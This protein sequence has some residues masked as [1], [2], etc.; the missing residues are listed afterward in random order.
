MSTTVPP[1]PPVGD[2]FAMAWSLAGLSPDGAGSSTLQR[3]STSP[4]SQ[5]PRLPQVGVGDAQDDMFSVEQRLGA[6]GMGV[7]D[8]ARDLVLDRTVAL[9]RP[10]LGAG[11]RVNG[12]LVSEAR[13]LAA[14][15][16][17]NIVPVHALGQDVDGAAILVMKRVIGLP[18][19]EIASRSPDLERDVRIALDGPDVP[20]QPQA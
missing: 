18:W 3:R 4:Q 7:V 15:D 12:A 14:L 13:T 11:P 19:K 17:P 1:S 8:A 10:R 20:T 16:H 6:G 5:A 9:K 2:T